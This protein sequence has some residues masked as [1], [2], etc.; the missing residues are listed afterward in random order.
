MRSFLPATLL[1]SLLLAACGGGSDDNSEGP[2][3]ADTALSVGGNSLVLGSSVSDA[4]AAALTATIVVVAGGQMGQ[5][6]PCTG[7]GSA[8]F[9]VSGGSGLLNGVLDAGE[10]YTIDFDQCRSSTGASTVDGVMQLTVVTASATTTVVDTSTQALTV[11]EP[12]RTL[13][14]NGSSTFSRSVATSGTTV[15]TT[16]RWQSPQVAFVSARNG[17]TASLTLSNVDLTS[18]STTVA[19]VPTGSTSSGSFTIALM[20]FGGWTAT[21]S[22]NGAASY[23]PGGVP[24]QGSWLLILPRDRIG[25]VVAAGVATVTVDH[26]NDG[27][28]ERTYTFN[29]GTLTASAS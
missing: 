26:G 19:G 22:S 14:I 20:G 27:S 5:T 6:I 29:V 11:V 7:G 15:V 9:I 3:S 21:F 1:A 24:V 12:D 28:V 18:T 8:S 4:H 2:A 17:R 25:L 16:E 13:T 23:T 10:T